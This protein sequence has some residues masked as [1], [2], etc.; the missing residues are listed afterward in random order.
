[1]P[2]VPSAPTAAFQPIDPFGGSEVFTVTKVVNVSQLQHEISVRTGI[3]YSAALSV[4]FFDQPVGKNN[5][6]TLFVTP[7]GVNRREVSDVIDA[8]VPSANFGKTPQQMNTE[9]IMDKLLK[10]KSLSQA[11]ITDLVQV[12]AAKNAQ[13]S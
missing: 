8:H 1:M 5:P 2:E 10:G 11:E 13:S 6:G 4:E 9:G 3:E 7:S 12:L